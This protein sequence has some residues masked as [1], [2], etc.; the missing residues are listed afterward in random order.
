VQRYSR[1]SRVEVALGQVGDLA[2]RWGVAGVEERD[3]R[4]PLLGVR[5]DLG[6]RIPHPLRGDWRGKDDAVGDLAGKP[7]RVGSAVVYSA[8]RVIGDW[9]RAPT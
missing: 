1:G 3:D 8:S 2:R 5:R 6:E 9:V 7:Q 4:E